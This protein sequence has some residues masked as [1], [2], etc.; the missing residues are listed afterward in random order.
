ML[1]NL[2]EWVA[3]ALVPTQIYFYGRKLIYWAAPIGIVESLL[4]ITWAYEKG[5]NSILTLNVFLVIIHIK[6]LYQEW[7]HGK[8]N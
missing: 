1:L 5:I 4:W 8:P 2:I 7:K 6:N 3:T